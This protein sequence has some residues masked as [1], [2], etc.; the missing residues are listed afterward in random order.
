MSMFII[1]ILHNSKKE[2]R[3]V[4]ATDM[5]S[6]IDKLKAVFLNVARVNPYESYKMLTPV[7]CVIS[8]K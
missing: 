3:V 5:L 8:N 7:L 6:A 2:L 4:E 1:P